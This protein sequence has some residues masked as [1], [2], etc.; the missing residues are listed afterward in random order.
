MSLAQA[1]N[2][3]AALTNT[4]FGLTSLL[5]LCVQAPAV[6]R[7]SGF[8]FFSAAASP[9]EG[10]GAATS[11]IQTQTESIEEIRARIFGTHIGNGLR[12][13]RKVLRQKLLGEQLAAY[14]PEDIIRSDPLMVNI[15]AERCVDYGN[16]YS[17]GVQLWDG[18]MLATFG[19]VSTHRS[20]PEG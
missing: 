3:P 11:S 7:R 16:G 13:G 5:P 18:K 4:Q 20:I 19:A 9:P 17:I 1:T 6:V 8:R 14:Y 15:K 10:A 12:S 2:V